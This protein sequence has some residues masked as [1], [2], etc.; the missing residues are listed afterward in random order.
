MC[1]IYLINFLK[2]KFRISNHKL[3][4]ENLDHFLDMAYDL[5]QKDHL[6]NFFNDGSRPAAEERETILRSYV[7]M[8]HSLMGDKIESSLI[9]YFGKE[10]LY[11]QI[12][13]Y[14]NFRLDND[15]VHDMLKKVQQSEKAE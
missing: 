8:V 3:Y 1:T 14:F 12:I 15:E 2:Y 4:T 5:V 6:L 10:T 13:S 7:K 11:I 9:D